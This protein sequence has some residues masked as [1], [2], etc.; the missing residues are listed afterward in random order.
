VALLQLQL[1]LTDKAKPYELGP[2]VDSIFA[3]LR[4]RFGLLA[5]DARVCLQGLWHDPRNFLQEHAATVERLTQIA[6]SDLSPVSRERYTFDAFVQSVND[7]D[8]HH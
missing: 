5:V 6:H 4:A 8:L 2:D 1:A 3:A 7:L